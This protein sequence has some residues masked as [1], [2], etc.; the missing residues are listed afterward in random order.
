MTVGFD[1]PGFLT[2]LASAIP[3]FDATDAD[4]AAILPQIVDSAELRV[5]RDIDLLVT[6]KYAT[7]PFATVAPG[8]ALV[9]PPS[10]MV[11]PRY[12]G[13]YTPAGSFTSWVGL[14]RKEESYLR[15]YWP[16][17]GSTAPPKYFALLGTGA[18]LISPSPDAAYISELGYTYR[19]TSLYGLGVGVTTYISANL[20][21][22]MFY[23][24]MIFVAGYQ[25]NFGAQADD[26]RSAVSW[27][28]E[29]ET[30]KKAAVAEEGRRKAEQWAD[31]SGS[32]P[33]AVAEVRVASGQGA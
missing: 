5:L 10:D 18:L 12:Y 6:R 32:E 30:A 22:V 24:A 25:K 11:V 19:P 27:L 21:D 3:A 9:Q 14:D 15:F 23:A 31:H 7:T 33:P 29:Y 1:Y 16:N 28:S 20:P 2:R 8:N 26:P 4:W 13:Y 17:R